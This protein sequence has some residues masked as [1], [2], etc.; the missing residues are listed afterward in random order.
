MDL[1]H[2]SPRPDPLEVVGGPDVPGP[3]NFQT[4]GPFLPE[5]VEWIEK[6]HDNIRIMADRKAHA[7]GATD[8]LVMAKGM[9]AIQPNLTPERALEAAIAF[10]AL[11]KLGR[12]LSAFGE[13]KPSPEDSWLDLETYALMAQ[14]VLETGSWP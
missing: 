3:F 2:E 7:Y 6:H 14:K 1:S 10:Y 9:Q 11:G 5:L 4:D 13:G 8:L 12:V